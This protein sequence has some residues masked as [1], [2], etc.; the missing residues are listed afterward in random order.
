LSF[1]RVPEPA[2]DH[3]ILS[4]KS[5]LGAARESA[6]DPERRQDPELNTCRHFSG[7]PPE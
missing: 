5:D 6:G 7:Y 2:Q 3:G 1:G 4:Q